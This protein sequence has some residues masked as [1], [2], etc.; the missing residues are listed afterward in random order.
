MKKC[1]KEN[2]VSTYQL[3]ELNRKENIDNPAITT[4]TNNLTSASGQT[5]SKANQDTLGLVRNN[6]RKRKA[7]LPTK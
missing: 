1:A 6:K 4:A 2:N 7:N 3:V 5:N